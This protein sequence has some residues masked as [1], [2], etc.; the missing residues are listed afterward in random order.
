LIGL[1]RKR[2]ELNKRSAGPQPVDAYD[3]AIDCAAVGD[4]E[5]A[6]RWLEKAIDARDHKSTLIGVEPI[7]DGLRSDP[8]FTVLLNRV[9]LKAVKN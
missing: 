6:L 2:I 5:Q 7:F 3:I 8:R 9:G 1:R 4:R